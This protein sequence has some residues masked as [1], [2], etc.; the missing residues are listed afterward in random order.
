MI[1]LPPLNQNTYK[2]VPNFNGNWLMQNFGIKP[3][4]QVGEIL[5]K[6]FQKFGTNLEHMPPEEVK[7]YVQE[8]LK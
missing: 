1:F 3:G 6:L 2:N 5:K 7:R 4:P 8:L